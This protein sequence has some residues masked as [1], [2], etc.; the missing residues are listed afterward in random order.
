MRWLLLAL[1][2]VLAACSSDPVPVDSGPV[3]AGWPWAD[4]SLDAG[5]RCAPGMSTTCSRGT[6]GTSTYVCPPSG[7]APAVCPCVDVDAALDVPGDSPTLVDAGS[8]A[9]AVADAPA[10]DALDA[11]GA[12][13]GADAV[14]VGDAVALEDVADVQ[15]VDVAADRPD[16]VAVDVP[17]DAGAVDGG[18]VVFDLEAVRTETSAVLLW[19]WTCSVGCEGTF[20]DATTTP[21]DCRLASDG[22]HFALSRCGS[23]TGLTRAGGVGTVTISTGGAPAQSSAVVTTQGAGYMAGGVA[24]RNFHVQFAAPPG[25]GSDGVT[26]IPGRTV[27]PSLGDVWLFGC[28]VE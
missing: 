16:V 23:V 11:G 9:V 8:D 21:G 6:L 10:V 27:S 7:L 17:R 18:P 14:A 19:G 28:R 20:C 26:G 15:L 22:L 5:T 25:G 2:L 13:A 24:R 1:P 4:G 3:D 12:D